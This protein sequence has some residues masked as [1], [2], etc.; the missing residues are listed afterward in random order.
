[1]RTKSSK[2]IQLDPG[3]CVACWKCVDVCP[4][5]ALGKVIIL[6]HKHVI[7]NNPNNCSG[8]RKCIEICSHGVISA[9]NT[10]A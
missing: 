2:F 10:K 7:L 5:Q 9:I 4:N 3:K 6:W 1:M 8:C